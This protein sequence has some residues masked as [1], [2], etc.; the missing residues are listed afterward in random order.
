MSRYLYR[1]ARWSY[2]H[3]WA[4][5]AG[6]IVIVVAAVV[7][8]GASGGKTTDAISIPGTEAQHAVSVLKAKLP[9]ASGATTQVVFA[10]EGGNVTSAAHKAG[11]EKT[12]KELKALPQVV[13]VSDPFTAGSVS[14]DK[15]VALATVTYNTPAAGNVKDATVDGLKPAASDARHA[16]VQVEFS[17][18][19]YPQAAE[20]NSEAVG[21]MVALIVLVL[22]FGSLVA[23]GMPLVTAV[24]GVVISMMGV[25][26]LS[27]FTDIASASTSVATMLGLSCAIDYALFI[28]SRARTNAAAG[29]SPE[30]A[31]SRA[32]GTAGSSVVFAGLSVMIALCGMSVVGIPF[33]TVM[34]LTAA[35][36]VGLALLVALTLL[37]A[38][39]G[40]VGSRGFR[41][42]RLP[43]LRR[44]RA[45]TENAAR[46][47]EK[48]AGTR[49]ASWVVRN[50][51]KVLVLGVVG[52]A[53][54]ALPFSKMDLG[55]P[56]ANARPTSD[57]SRVAYD[58]TSDHFGAGYNGTLT[59]VA[60]DVD[61]T[62]QAQ[63]VAAALGKVDG[64]VS[65]NVAAV[66]NGIAVVSVVPSTGPNDPKTADLVHTIRDDSS[67]IAAD[68]G[69]HI[70]V[71]GQTA[72]DIDV[73]AKLSDA[74]PVFLAT[75]VVLA[76]LLLTFAFRTILVPLKSILGFLLSA[77][78]ALGAQVAVFQWGWGQH[79]L[80]IAPTQT[81][82]FLPVILL[83]IMFG[84]S[85]DYEIFVVSRI[86]E[87]YTRTG[88]ARAAAVQGT[89]QSAR[90]VT[91]AALIMA[92][93][94]ASFLFAND[95]MIK[96]IGFSFAVGVLIDA[97]VVRLALVPALMAIAGSRIWYHPR[98]FARV[99]PDPD[100]EGERLEE[101]LTARDARELTT[102]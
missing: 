19:V 30:E 55:L 60:Q 41:Y 68:T 57:T 88:D 25:T 26:I 21:M 1:L 29:H 81:L 35:A 22:T 52:L 75:V 10:D 39:V 71:G 102:V 16:G 37:P 69:A 77:G 58:L 42:S 28:L 31:V 8:A 44:A 62:A 87:H 18:A 7:L 43:G 76:F 4:T 72:T 67:R 100:I 49:W 90:V 85:S 34:G 17:G 47:P 96:S 46:D 2:R 15:Q 94:F 92:S 36:T 98:W 82:S 73:S 86:K 97:F 93:I 5:L 50:R 23:G 9:A 14:P 83:A 78:A 80:G 6:W 56:G 40:V 54:I 89:G 65:S 48:L 91:S 51:V 32:A 24:F 74:L 3:R 59:V 95:P 12:L 84:L 33:L 99:V 79:L 63:Q 61:R 27:A 66:T 64:V 53:V 38:L 20:V 70:L 11:V 13:A 101:E 45:A